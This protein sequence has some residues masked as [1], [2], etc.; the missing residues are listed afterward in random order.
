MISTIYCSGSTTLV[1]KAQSLT[2]VPRLPSRNET[3]SRLRLG[4]PGSHYSPRAGQLTSMVSLIYMYLAIN[5]HGLIK[6]PSLK[7]MWIWGIPVVL[8]IHVQNFMKFLTLMNIW[9]CELTHST[10]KSMNIS[11]QR[12]MVKWHWQNTIYKCI[13]GSFVKTVIIIKKQIK[14]WR[15]TG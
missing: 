13:T 6:S 5:C 4:S 3:T 15:W 1:V 11:V 7:E 12:I 10:I 2:V 9:L 14:E 8:L